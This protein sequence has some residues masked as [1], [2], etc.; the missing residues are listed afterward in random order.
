MDQMN[1]KSGTDAR[2]INGTTGVTENAVI[3]SY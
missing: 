2:F 1:T 3:A